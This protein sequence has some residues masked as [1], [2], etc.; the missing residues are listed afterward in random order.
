MYR[1]KYISATRREDSQVLFHFANHFL[2]CSVRQRLLAIQRSA[3]ERQ[4]VAKSEYAKAAKVALEMAQL[5]ANN[6]DH[7]VRHQYY[8]RIT[9]HNHNFISAF[10]NTP[11]NTTNFLRVIQM[12][13]GM[14]KTNEII[15]AIELYSQK[16]DTNRMS[17]TAIKNA[18]GLIGD[19]E[20]KL[21]VDLQLTKH[22]PDSYAAWF[23]LSQTHIRLKQTNEST[24]A[25]LKALDLFENSETKIPDIIPIL[26]TN[27][28]LK[29]LREQPEIKNI[30]KNN[31]DRGACIS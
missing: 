21:K 17:L 4:L 24:Q 20:G 15:Q 8:Q 3:P 14:R 12:Y 31:Y 22:E 29:P 5:D 18:Y 27:R 6:P 16:S 11:N 28:L 1:R 30:L 26:R 2:G 10:N 19:W 23:D 7:L 13:G 25:M 9:Q